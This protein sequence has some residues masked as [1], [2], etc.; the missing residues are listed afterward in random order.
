VG[1][2]LLYEVAHSLKNEVNHGLIEQYG[3]AGLHEPTVQ[4]LREI[5]C[6]IGWS[7]PPGQAS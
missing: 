1:G 6:E 5:L 4:K 3:P 2:I 7:T